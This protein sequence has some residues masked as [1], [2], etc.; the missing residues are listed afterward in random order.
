MSLT[1]G[2]IS[3]TSCD[4]VDIALVDFDTG[5]QLIQAGFEPYPEEI[6]KRL[7]QLIE[8]QHIELS[9]YAELDMQLG[10][11]FAEAAQ[12]FLHA[13]NIPHNQVTAIGSHG[14]T[15]FHQPN[16][17]MRNTIQLGAPQR[18]AAETGIPVVARF[19]ELDMAYAGQGAPLAPA[20]HRALFY[21]GVP[22]AA[23]NLGGIANI[24][25]FTEDKTYGFDT[26][27]ASCLMDGWIQQHHAK[28][29]DADGAW[30]AEGQLLPDLLAQMLNEPYFHQAAPKSTGRELFNQYWLNQQLNGNEY[31][32]ADVQC[33]LAH[34]TAHSI[35]QGLQFL[36]YTAQ[37]L[38]ICGGGAHNGFLMRLLSSL[39]PGEVFSS[40][41][42]GFDGDSV[43]AV[44]M[45]WLADQYM[46]GRT[47]DLS[48]VTGAEKALRY[49]VLF[50]PE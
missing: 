5:I 28:A 43:E 8:S 44:L 1:L 14:Q 50:T 33:T 48:S 46:K 42:L 26:G 17:D 15:I 32:A 2:L 47:I 49:G 3:G 36:P 41:E 40:S 39:F 25:G 13:H 45:A 37:Q 21:K 30:A 16:G 23:V 9:V 7:H 35:V 6:Q 27:P 10:V 29:Y 38:V 24:S 31:N 34:L 19:R 18:I 20:I 12:R 11:F 22:I 4:G